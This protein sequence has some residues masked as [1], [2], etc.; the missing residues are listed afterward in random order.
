MFVA[1][2]CGG[3]TINMDIQFIKE[4]ID[5]G[6]ISKRKHPTENLYI[7]NY[8]TSC[9]YDWIWNRATITCR[10]LIVDDKW[11]IIARPFPKFFTMEQYKNLRNFVYQLYN[12]KYKKAFS[13]E[14]VCTKKIDGALGI[15]YKNSNGLAIATRGSFE[16]PQAIKATQIL[17]QKLDKN[18]RT[19]DLDKYTYLFEIIYPENRI[20]VDYG[21]KEELILLEVLCNDTGKHSVEETKS[22]QFYFDYAEKKEIKSLEEISSVEN[23]EGYVIRFIDTDFRVKV[24]FDEYLKLHKLLTGL[25]K[26]TILSWL[27]DDIDYESFVATA[28]ISQDTTNWINETVSSFQKEYNKILAHVQKIIHKELVKRKPPLTRKKLAI[29]YNNY[30]YKSVMF[31]M[32]DNKEYKQTIWRIVRQNLVKKT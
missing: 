7:L 14:F 15:L 27:R 4:M 13:G 17:K 28:S 26:K 2:I 19:F 10:G 21:N 16:S 30:A 20:V 11:N 23:E 24:K 25:S 8:T 29:K 1:S 9:Q 22:T 5:K 18:S 3:E 31:Q 12:V 32:L 6:Y